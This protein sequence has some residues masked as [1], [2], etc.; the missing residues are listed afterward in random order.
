MRSDA[1]T[2]SLSVSSFSNNS[3]IAIE[4]LQKIFLFRMKFVQDY[5]LLV[6]SNGKKMFATL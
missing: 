6:E 4:R 2:R 3:R 1:S 5:P